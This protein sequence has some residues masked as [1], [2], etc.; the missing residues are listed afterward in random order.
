M[1][2]KKRSYHEKEKYRGY[3]YVLPWVIGF[4]GLTLIPFL[5]LFYF[6]FTDYNIVS[7]PKWA[8]LANYIKIFTQDSKVLISLKATFQYAVLSVP[9][10]LATAL[11]V[12]MLLNQKRKGIG[13]YRTLFYIPSIIGGSIA[14][15]VMW[16]NLFSREGAVNSLIE[17]IFGIKPDISWIADPKTAMACL[18]LL[19]MWQFGAPMIIFLAGLKNIPQSLYEAAEVDGANKFHCFFKITLPMLSPII[20]FNL[21]MQMI[22]GF[23]VFTQGLVIT[24]GGP[25]NKTLFYQLYVYQQGFKQFN[26]GYASALSC[27]MLVI[28]LLLTAL[29]FK[30]S[31]AWV[32]YESEAK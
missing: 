21:V 13:I 9:C 14:V 6:S 2:G 32:Y 22:N 24:N 3:L 7:A 19:T 10:K 16:K 4:V 5:C 12:A 17:T 23:M 29:V 1:A 18:I 25:L 26:M 28:I 30:S 20:F 11:V 31:S 27:V 8:G 15:A